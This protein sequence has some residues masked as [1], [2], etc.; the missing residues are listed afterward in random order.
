[1]GFLQYFVQ[2]NL[3]LW[4]QFNVSQEDFDQICLDPITDEIPMLFNLN[5]LHV[6]FS[7]MY[8]DTDP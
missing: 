8:T 1:M 4:F 7:M 6:Y 5:D 2:N 3:L